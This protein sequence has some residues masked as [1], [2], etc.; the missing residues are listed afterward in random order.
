MAM[1]D[2]I[3]RSEAIEAVRKEYEDA[4]N[5]GDNGD[6][7]AYDVARILSALPSAE[8]VQG[9]IQCSERL[10]DVDVEVLTTTDWSEGLIAWLRKD[11]TWETDEYILANDEILAW[12]PLPTPYKGGDDE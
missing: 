2:T 9:W 3:Y 6:A 10:P 1:N 4:I 5:I 8:A 7:I 11:G 12:M